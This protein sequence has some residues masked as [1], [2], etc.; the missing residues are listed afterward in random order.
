MKFH[1][2]FRPGDLVKDRNTG[3]EGVIIEAQAMWYDKYNML[4]YRG[5]NEIKRRNPAW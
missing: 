2:Q 5:C 3:D 1:T 4:V